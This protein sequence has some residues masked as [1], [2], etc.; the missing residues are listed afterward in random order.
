MESEAADDRNDDGHETAGD[1]HPA[2]G[3]LRVR[4]FFGLE[5]FETVVRG[6]VGSLVRLVL[7]E[8][9]RIVPELTRETDLSITL[10]RFSL[11]RRRRRLVGANGIPRVT[12]FGISRRDGADVS[13]RTPFRFCERSGVPCLC[14]KVLSEWKCRRGLLTLFNNSV[15]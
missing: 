9:L 6:L 7:E 14:P 2:L 13:T 3:L 12:D 1:H 5:V 10:G 8:R 4:R 11:R 15:H